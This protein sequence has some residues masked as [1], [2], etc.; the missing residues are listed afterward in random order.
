MDCSSWQMFRMRIGL[1]VDWYP[2]PAISQCGSGSGQCHHPENI[3]HSSHPLSK[4]KSFYP[5][6][7]KKGTREKLGS[8]ITVKSVKNFLPNSRS[9][10][11]PPR[12]VSSTR[13]IFSLLLSL[14]QNSNLFILPQVQKEKSRGQNQCKKC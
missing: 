5:N 12:P 14:F 11:L 8:R 3:F 7:I 13:K 1:N 4:F 6:A 2:D 10:S 9:C